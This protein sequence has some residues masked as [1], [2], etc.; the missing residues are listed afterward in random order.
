MAK[1][2]SNIRFKG[3]LGENVGFTGANGQAFIRVAK[4]S[5]KNPRTTGQNISRMILATVATSIGFLSEI[6]NNSVQNKQRGAETLAYLRGEWMRSL[7][8]ADIFGASNKNNYAL[9][10]YNGFT[11]NRY[12]LS[13]GSLYAPS[14]EMADGWMNLPVTELATPTAVLTANQLFP[15]IAVGDQITLIFCY[16][17]T[18]APQF[19]GM[20]PIRCEYLRFAFKDDITPALIAVDGGFKLNSAAVAINK[21]E[22]RW[23]S[24]IFRAETASVSAIVLGEEQA[25]AGAILVSNIEGGKRSTSYMSVD[26][27]VEGIMW[28]AVDA[29]P[30]YGNQSV[31]Y[32]FASEI[33]LNNST[34][35][36]TGGTVDFRV[37]SADV[38]NTPAVI[39]AGVVNISIPV[40]G[41]KTLNLHLNKE[42]TDESQ[43]SVSGSG[44]TG[45]WQPQ[46]LPLTVLPY[47]VSAV[48]GSNVI[49]LDGVAVLTVVVRVVIEQP[50][51]TG[52]T[53]FQT[54]TQVSMAG[55]AG[56]EIHYTTDG[57]VPS[58]AS[59]LYSE[60]IELTATTTVKAIAIKDG[61]SSEVASATFT[62]RSGSDTD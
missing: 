12:L 4:D 15:N 53:P 1:Q 14:V 31:D 29:E 6:L 16:R 23:K 24:V 41:T 46:D 26:D 56:A 3:K 62:K 43:A 40:G 50:T 36:E 35:A 47:T 32:D 13:K 34:N 60:A 19:G 22:G 30:T 54:S 55:P 17:D 58:S 21:A 28:P 51:I 20:Y 52:T 7:R 61:I 44:V 37:A 49:S 42:F 10:G 5:V 38:D 18:N 2:I 27:S 48:A 39:T 9:K 25:V 33:Y 11:P 59:P 8:V 45:A 57:S